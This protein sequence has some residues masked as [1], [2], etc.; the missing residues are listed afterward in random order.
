MTYLF[1]DPKRFPLDAVDGLVA[2]H[3]EEL[4]RVHGGVVRR[5]ATPLGQ[6]ALVVG[7]GSGHYPAFAGW[8]GPGFAHGA[9][10]GNIFS[11]PSSDQVYSVAKNAENGGGVVFGFGNY[12]GDVL[13]FGVAAEK[14]RAEGVDVR[15]IAVSDD[16]ASGAAS[17]L[18]DRRG[19][20]GDMTVF[21][22]TG[23]AIQAGADIDEAERIA[24]KAND[25]SR[26]LGVAF[27]G[28]TL[29]GATDA[30]FH[31]ESGRMAVGLG[32][33]GEPGID[34]RPI[35]T[36]EELASMLVDGVLAD[37]TGIITGRAAVLLNGLGTVKY[38]ELFVVWKHVSE[39]LSAK[40]IAVVQPEVGEHVT[41]L[42]M[43]GLSLTLMHL[44]GELESL[45]LA[46]VDT[47]ALRRGFISDQHGE[48]V[49]DAPVYEP[50]SDPIPSSSAESQE[51]AAAILACLRRIEQGLREKEQELGHIDQIAGDGDHGQGM[52]LG[53]QAAVDSAQKA[54]S[55]GCGARTVL[56]QAGAAWS[57]VAGGT[58]GALWGAAL[59]SLGTS[60]TDSEPVSGFQLADGLVR[61]VKAIERLG[62]AKPGQKTMVDAAVPFRQ[63]ITNAHVDARA[64]QT[65][66]DLGA[67][68]RDAAKAAERAAQETAA[69][70]A[71]KGRSRHHGEKSIGTPD[72][73]AI[74]FALI[75]SCL[76][77]Y[78][79]QV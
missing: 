25:M 54:V 79:E 7:G 1:N 13:H 43:A 76:A 19:I 41:S 44:D 33:H 45:W 36:A 59:T 2:A 20:A 15:I 16:I 74:S 38:E 40:G 73:G 53:S 6:P 56:V 62:G 48:P 51:S 72:P 63:V 24:W 58:S 60:F 61:A 14:L 27:D 21:K 31:V 32:I 68:L 34:E 4:L 70:P 3:P 26:T 30:L 5:R 66:H 37:S 8:V 10:C 46:P 29:P 64:A 11:S 17:Q 35:P 67:V 42:D 49:R 47:P 78:I 9:P 23:A 77:D 71:L 39:L 28:C 50:G 12:A 75:V 57:A 69:I 52:A 18:R 65:V 22:A 55:K